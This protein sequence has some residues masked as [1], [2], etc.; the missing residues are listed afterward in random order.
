[1]APIAVDPGVVRTA[2][3]AQRQRWVLAAA[4]AGVM[5]TS[6]AVQRHDADASQRTGTAGGVADVETTVAPFVG[7]AD[8]PL[9]MG[10]LH[11]LPAEGTV[12]VEPPAPAPDETAA[13]EP[14]GALPDGP[15]EFAR[16][17]DVRLVAEGSSVELVAFHES[18]NVGALTLSTPVLADEGPVIA[19]PTRN[20]PG[21]PTSAVDVAMAPGQPVMAPVDGEVLSVGD[22]A[23]YGSTPDTIIQ[24]RPDAD[25]DV[26][27]TVVHVAEPSIAAGDRVTAG[28]T[29]IAGEARQLPFDSQI[30]RFT[31]AYRGAA[32]P[33]IHVE[34]A[35]VTRT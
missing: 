21:S 34:L 6:Q 24:I 32:A 5:L 1:M 3:P 8:Q 26:V 7:P 18:S 20:R 25:P 28:A 10:M 31:T 9:A 13:T 17:G 35:R 16:Y 23:L 19:L 14:S 11:P 4:V 29:A 15:A 12:V 27:V 33:H 22:Y 2:S 30:D